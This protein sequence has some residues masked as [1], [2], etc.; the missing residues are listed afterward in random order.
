MHVRYYR[1]ICLSYVCKC[2]YACMQQCA[3]Y[4]CIQ[5]LQYGCVSDISIPSAVLFEK[6]TLQFKIRVQIY[7]C[8]HLR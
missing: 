3:Y 2:A 7:V 8:N 1:P 4:Q 5:H 6:I